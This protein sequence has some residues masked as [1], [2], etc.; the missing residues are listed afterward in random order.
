MNKTHSKIYLKVLLNTVK[1][2]LHNMLLIIKIPLI[3]I[4]FLA[5]SF[6]TSITA[7]NSLVSTRLIWYIA[8]ADI[9]VGAGT[10]Y[11]VFSDND[12][13]CCSSTTSAISVSIIDCADTNG[14][15]T[16]GINAIIDNT[17]G[18]LETIEEN[19]EEIDL[20]FLRMI[21]AFSN[22]TITTEVDFRRIRI[23][24]DRDNIVELYSTITL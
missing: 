5:F 17:N 14:D 1:A 23:D 16:I 19:L 11:A 9:T 13:N 24:T 22:F 20:N 12:N 18:I 21:S 6:S 4:L 2:F 3:S 7:S 10:Y 15:N 8:T